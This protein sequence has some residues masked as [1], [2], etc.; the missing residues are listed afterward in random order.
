MFHNFNLPHGNSE[1]DEN[2]EE[3]QSTGF[4]DDPLDD[5]GEGQQFVDFEEGLSDDE[6]HEAAFNRTF[7][8]S[9]QKQSPQSKSKKSPRRPGD[10]DTDVSSPKTKKARTLTLFGGGDTHSDEDADDEEMPPKTPGQGIGMRMSSLTLE[11]QDELG[12]DSQVEHADNGGGSSRSRT[13]IGAG[14]GLSDREDSPALSEHSS[15]LDD[16]EYRV[17]PG[18]SDMAYELRQNIDRTV[19]GPTWMDVDQS[20]T[21]D[22]AAE[23]KEKMLKLNKAKAKKKNKGMSAPLPCKE[24]HDLQA[25][26]PVW[27]MG[28]ADLLL[29]VNRKPPRRSVTCRR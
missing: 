2:G 18:T 28:C 25:R 24:T 14:L 7:P 23:A 16:D 17:R 26:G 8:G 29:Q 5:D 27:F 3:H 13:G 19:A 6:G 21:Y 15:R 1:M 10:D 4:G 12:P 22:P 20:G 11:Q 9:K